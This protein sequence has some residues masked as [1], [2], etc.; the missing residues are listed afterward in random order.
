MNSRHWGDPLSLK[1]LEPRKPVW[2][3]PAQGPDTEKRDWWLRRPSV[4]K[5]YPDYS[6]ALDSGVGLLL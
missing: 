4:S 5:V 1:D 2:L 3:H 6:S